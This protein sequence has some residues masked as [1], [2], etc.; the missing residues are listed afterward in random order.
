VS[1][2]AQ[3]VAELVAA[4]LSGGALV[5]ACRRIERADG[6]TVAFVRPEAVAGHSRKNATVT[7]VAPTPNAT[8]APGAGAGKAPLAILRASI[9]NATHLTR[10]A[11]RVGAAILDRFDPA[12]G[13]CVIG[14]AAIS[15]VCGM[16]RASV[17]RAIKALVSARLIERVP[18]G[19]FNHCNAY[20]PCLGDAAPSRTA[21][22]A[23][24]RPSQAC[25]PI[26]ERY[27][28]P[29]GVSGGAV[30]RKTRQ[31]VPDRRQQ[32]L[33]LVLTG[34]RS[35][36][37]PAFKPTPEA[38]RAKAIER[39]L[40]DWDARHRGRAIRPNPQAWEAAITAEMRSAG[41]G[42]AAYDAVE[43]APLDEARRRT[44]SGPP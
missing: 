12:T 34:G 36:A 26:S 21:T 43:L 15:R 33:P 32:H 39:L 5:A 38:L 35:G 31:S 1:L 23:Q 10:S 24:I 16:H 28:T 7:T 29:S 42:L 20:I 13:R 4:G 18:Y 3:V 19:G 14:V 2:S 6:A 25:D 22:V 44:G 30:G 27:T 8:V 9:A 11:A 40:K 17:F 41:T 37:V